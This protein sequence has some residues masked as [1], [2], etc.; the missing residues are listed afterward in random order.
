LA[1]YKVLNEFGRRSALET[2]GD[3]RDDR[4]GSATNLIA[5]AV[6]LRECSISREN[7]D[8]I[9][10]FPGALIDVEILEGFCRS[11]FHARVSTNRIHAQDTHHAS[12]IFSLHTLRTFTVC[13]PP[14]PAANRP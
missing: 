14:A 7:V 12:V 5:Q 11:P 2:L 8:A 9:C 6:I 13:R 4:H 3:V 1:T 10:Q